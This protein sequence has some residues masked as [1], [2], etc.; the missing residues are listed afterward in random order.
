MCARPAPPGHCENV[1]LSL[2]LAQYGTRSGPDRTKVLRFCLMTRGDPPPPRRLS[3]A[4]AAAAAGETEI[5]W[6]RLQ[7]QVV[8]R[9]GG[10]VSQLDRGPGGRRRSNRRRRSHR[11]IGDAAELAA[12][13]RKATLSIR[14]PAPSST[15]RRR[16]RLGRF[17]HHRGSLHPAGRRR[18]G[19]EKRRMPWM[20]PLCPSPAPSPAPPVRTFAEPRTTRFDGAQRCPGGGEGWSRW[21]RDFARTTSKETAVVRCF[22]GVCLFWAPLPSPES[23]GQGGP[24]PDRL[25]FCARARLFLTLPLRTVR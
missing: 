6:W 8:E 4:A 21:K 23:R 15:S 22:V 24:R 3:A 12:G 5:C 18:G 11:P 20:P 7:L 14:A 10:V 9:G 17:H 16:R 13:W 1:C 25:E 19:K 2:S